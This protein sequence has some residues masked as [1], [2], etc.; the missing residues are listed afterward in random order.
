MAR[1]SRNWGVTLVEGGMGE[2]KTNTA[3]GFIV[4][5]YKKMGGNLQIFTVNIHLYGNIKYVYCSS[6][7]ELL[8]Y[9]N[10][11]VVKDGI[12]VIDE[13]YIAGEARRGHNPLTVLFTWFGNQIRKRHLELYIIVQNGRF[14]DWRFRWMFYRR[15]LCKYDARTKMVTLNIKY[16]KDGK[17]KTIHYWAPQYWKYFDTDELPHIPEKMIEKAGA[18]A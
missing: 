17:E 11:D 3:V 8:R 1:V 6:M 2:G 4:D 10:S 9:C 18:W 13:A 12:L 14:I 7:A 5:E 16:P 15:I